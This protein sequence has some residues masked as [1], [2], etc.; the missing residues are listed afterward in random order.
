MFFQVMEGFLYLDV[1]NVSGVSFG[2]A[3][4]IFVT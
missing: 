1:C 2:F 3:V 4:E